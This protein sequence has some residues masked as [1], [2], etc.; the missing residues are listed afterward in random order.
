VG[1][2]KDP[3]GRGARILISMSFAEDRLPF[4][5][6]KKPARRDRVP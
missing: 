3:A 4:S 1:S 5:P 2:E 6:T